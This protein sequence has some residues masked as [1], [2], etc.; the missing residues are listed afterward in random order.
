M[1]RK[2]VNFYGKAW[3]VEWNTD[4]ACWITDAGSAQ[5]IE[6]R[7][8]GWTSDFAAWSRVPAYLRRIIHR[9]LRK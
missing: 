5:T 7:A 4:K 9:R 1:K 6:V 8:D 2:Q 3:T